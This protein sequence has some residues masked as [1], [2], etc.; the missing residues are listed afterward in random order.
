MGSNVVVSCNEMCSPTTMRR[1][2]YSQAV[3]C[4]SAAHTGPTSSVFL[5]PSRRRC[6]TATGLCLKP[7]LIGAVWRVEMCAAKGGSKQL[8]ALSAV[9]SK[10]VQ[11]FHVL[12]A[13][14]WRNKSTR[15]ASKN[16]PPLPN[17]MRG[18]EER[19]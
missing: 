8:E 7:A 3:L 1:M 5:S 16:G 6:D 17:T 14:P 4:P 10:L 9:T 13:G 15:D 11:Q 18:I 19:E 2:G 12:R